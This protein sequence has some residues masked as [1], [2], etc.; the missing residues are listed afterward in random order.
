VNIKP[1]TM[2]TVISYLHGSEIT[3]SS[4]A[5]NDIPLLL[6]A[7]AFGIASLEERV[8]EHLTQ[9]L[10]H[11]FELITSEVQIIELA[12]ALPE[13]YGQLGGEVSIG[14]EVVGVVASTT[15]HACCRKLATLKKSPEF[16]ALL[17]EI[18][19]LAYD[20]LASDV[21]V[22]TMVKKDDS[23]VRSQE[24]VKS[25]GDLEQEISRADG[26]KSFEGDDGVSNTGGT[27]KKGEVTQV[28]EDAAEETT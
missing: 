25:A 18:P 20:I 7:R 2:Q 8:K 23:I 15:A 17:K 27:P 28:V 22:D 13:L 24:T 19:Q 14:K 16:M 5:K 9:K 21:E 12:T 11:Q 6:A 10:D 4:I 1:E 26:L 3:D